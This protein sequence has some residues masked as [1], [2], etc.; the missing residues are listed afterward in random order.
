[1]DRDNYANDRPISNLSTI[2]KVVEHL[3]LSRLNPF[4]TL[5]PHFKLLQSAYRTGHSIRTALLKV[6]NDV[7]RNVEEKASTVLVAL[8]VSAA[9]ETICHSTLIDRLRDECG[10]NGI[11]LSWIESYISGRSIS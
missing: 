10:V 5:S 9:F 11:A 1:M 2:S 6:L 3:A 7:Y 8:D 4:L